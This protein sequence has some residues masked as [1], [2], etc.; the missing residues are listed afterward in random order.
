MPTAK[1]STAKTA[2]MPAAKTAAKATAKPAAKS[3][4]AKGAEEA[5]SSKAAPNPKKRADGN[6]A[7][8]RTPKPKAPAKDESYPATGKDRSRGVG[9][10]TEA[11]GRDHPSQQEMAKSLMQK[12]H[13]AS[14]KRIN[15]PGAS[16]GGPRGGFDARSNARS[17]H[18]AKGN[19]MMRRTQG[20]GG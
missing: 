12:L 11:T 7:A 16:H 6:T 13:G 5:V 1:K 9:D 4:V 8:T 18:T 10:H 19:S 15:G 3:G 2:A 20:K 17:A 14:D